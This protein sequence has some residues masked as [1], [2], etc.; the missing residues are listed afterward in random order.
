MTQNLKVRAY[1]MQ[2][3]V[4]LDMKK[5]SDLKTL[6]FGFWD[7]KTT[8]RAIWAQSLW[9]R[10]YQA[11]NSREPQLQFSEAGPCF[12]QNHEKNPIKS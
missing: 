7:L 1:L 10:T 4:D 3:F 8:F 11:I 6:K 5:F 9:Q 12:V 2:N